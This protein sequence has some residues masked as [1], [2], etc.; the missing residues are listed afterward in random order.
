MN[1][2]LAHCTVQSKAVTGNYFFLAG[3]TKQN[4]VDLVPCCRFNN[5]Y[6][7]I[8]FGEAHHR[9][10]KY[11]REVPQE[12]AVGN[13]NNHVTQGKSFDHINNDHSQKLF[14]AEGA[15]AARFGANPGKIGMHRFEN[16]DVLVEDAA[17]PVVALLKLNNYL[18]NSLKKS[19][20]KIPD[21]NNC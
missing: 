15:L 3:L 5:L 7:G 10:G 16:A 13:T 21:F 8:Q 9:T 17:D 6:G 18:A 14:A 11:P 4:R 19:F 20:I 2:R 12:V 1:V